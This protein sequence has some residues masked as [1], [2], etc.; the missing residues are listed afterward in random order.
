MLTDNSGIKLEINSKTNA[1]CRW[2]TPVIPATQ[3][4]EISRI[5][6]WLMVQALSS[7]LSTAKKKKSSWA[8]QYTLNTLSFQ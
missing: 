3:E 4:A 2:L 1:G 6:K 8:E 7:S 5:T